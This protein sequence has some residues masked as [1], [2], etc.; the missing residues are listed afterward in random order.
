MRLRPAALACA[1]LLACDGDPQAP[2]A[3][4]L[5]A[6]GEPPVCDIPWSSQVLPGRV[7]CAGDAIAAGEPGLLLATET[8]D[9]GT[10]Q[11]ER[12]IWL[13]ADGT[14]IVQTRERPCSGACGDAAWGAPSA[15][16][17]CDVAIDPALVEACRA[18]ATDV[19]DDCTWVP[20]DALTNC[21]PADEPTCDIF[22]D[23]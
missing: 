14:A 17:R 15:P 23:G 5:F 1:L 13:Q 12:L 10:S 22:Q 3:V 6:C 2:A 19:C 9:P 16:E 20:D 7:V 4:D 21:A 18:C 8:V 11:R